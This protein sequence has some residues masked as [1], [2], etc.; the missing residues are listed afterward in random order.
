MDS[1]GPST[2]WR[3]SEFEQQY[4]T[5]STAAGTLGNSL[6][7]PSSL[8]GE[9]GALERREC[10]SDVVEV[11]AACRRTQ[12]AALIFLRLDELIWPITLFPAEGVYHSRHDLLEAFGPAPLNLSVL[13][14]EAANLKPPVLHARER[15]DQAEFFRP[16]Q[17]A[18]WQLALCSPTQGLLR[19][20]GGPAAYRAL[21]SLSTDRLQ[22]PGALG[23]AA[24]RLHR[25]A[26]ALRHG[27]SVERGVRLLNALYLTSNLLVSRS[28]PLARAE[29]TS[30]GRPRQPSSGSA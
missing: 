10:E 23:H 14:V 29:P 6:L 11:L 12:E 3:L 13:A 21:R 15:G 1:G 27:M 26:A 18:L 19:E 2:L 30:K 17:P 9:L 20:I 5:R 7:M 4:R 22:A 24:E 25:E 16:L 28:H 8:L